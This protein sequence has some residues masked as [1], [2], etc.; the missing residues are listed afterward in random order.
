MA[1]YLDL[2]FYLSATVL[3]AVLT[4][5]QALKPASQSSAPTVSSARSPYLENISIS[6]APAPA[7]EEKEAS[8]PALQDEG[9]APRFY[10]NH[11]FSIEESMSS[12]FRYA[13]LMDVEVEQLSNQPLYKYIDEWWGTPYRLGGSSRQGIDCSAFVQGLMGSVY[14]I[15]L[16]R[17]ARE[18]KDYCQPL[19]MDELKEGDLIFFNTR[20]GVSHVGV[21]L[22]NNHFVHAATSGGIMISSLEESYWQRRMLGAG[23]PANGSEIYNTLTSQ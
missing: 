7:R 1:K 5:C 9:Y 20:G 16:P 11:A 8:M 15:S 21:Y 18:Q 19:R 17:V 23:R 6:S 3:A 12:Q 4:G 14:G 10:F 2:K 13:I 22:H